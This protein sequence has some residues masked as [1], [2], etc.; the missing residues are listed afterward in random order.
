MGVIVSFPLTRMN[1]KGKRRSNLCQSTDDFV[2]KA[3]INDEDCFDIS[4][5]PRKRYLIQWEPSV[6]SKR[7]KTKFK[8]DI[9]HITNG[10]IYWRNS[11]VNEDEIINK[12]IIYEYMLANKEY[13]LNHL[14][15]CV[16]DEYRRREDCAKR[17]KIMGDQFMYLADLLL[18]SA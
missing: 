4:F 17:Q 16:E 11:W 9:D 13:K 18:N 6:E 1:S 2:I 15:I 12:N 7:L 14:L 5:F 10:Q 8:S 3:I